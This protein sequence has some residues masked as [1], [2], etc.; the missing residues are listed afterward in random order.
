MFAVIWYPPR[1]GEYKITI[2]NTENR[3]AKYYVS[4]R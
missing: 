4:V 3:V 1:D 2:R